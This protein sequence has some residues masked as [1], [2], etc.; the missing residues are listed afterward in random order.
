MAVGAVKIVSATD[1]ADFAT[2]VTPPANSLPV[3]VPEERSDEKSDD[4]AALPC[5]PYCLPPYVELHSPNC[6]GR[7]RW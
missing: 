1:R 3:A 6:M 2:I 4:H 7:D 5:D